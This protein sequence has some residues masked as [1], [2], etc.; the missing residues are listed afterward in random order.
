MNGERLLLDAT[1]VAG[2]LNPRDQVM[3]GLFH[4][5]DA[6]FDSFRFFHL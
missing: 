6:L 3:N 4:L 1:F 2:Y 5:H